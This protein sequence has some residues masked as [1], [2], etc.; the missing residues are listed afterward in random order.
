MNRSSS[1]QSDRPDHYADYDDEIDLADY[2]RVLIKRKSFILITTLCFA[3]AG[4]VFSWMNK[5]Y[6]AQTLILLSLKVEEK[7]SSQGET[8]GNPGSQIVIPTLSAQTYEVLATTD[9]MHR[10]LRD[11]LTIAWKDSANAL[12]SYGLNA[13]I[14]Q[15]SGTSPSQLLTFKV[16]SPDPTA[17]V[18]V[19]NTWTRLF[20]ERNRGLSSGVA[21]SYYD[22]ALDQ[23][24]VARINLTEA[25]MALQSLQAKYHN[26]NMVQNEVNVKNTELDASLISYQAQEVALASKTR[27]L[28]YVQKLITTLEVN[29]EWIGF[30]STDQLPSENQVVHE[31]ESMAKTLTL[32]MHELSKLEQDSIAVTQKYENEQFALQANEQNARLRFTRDRQLDAIRQR[33]GT[34]FATLET[35]RV[36]LP[37]L[38]KKSK[39][40]DIELGVYRQNLEQ[41]KPFL[42][43]S[44][45]ITDEA[46]WDQVSHNGRVSENKQTDLSRYKLQSEQ[47][48]PVY[49]KLWAQI[50][51]LRI[52][53]DLMQQRIA[54]LD[55]EIPALQQDVVSG[56]DRLDS[57]LVEE[58]WLDQR[59]N[60]TRFAFVKKMDRN[61]TSLLS[62]LQR[63]RRLFEDLRVFYFDSKQ[64]AQTL[65]N[66]IE[67]IQENFAFQQNRFTN[68]RDEVEGLST[69][70]DSL[71]MQ[72]VQ[73]ERNIAVY[74][75][76]FTRFSQL[77]EEARI[78][79]EQAAGDLQVVSWAAEVGAR[80]G[81][82]Y[83]LIIVFAGGMVS[84][85]MAF[86]LEYVEKAKERLRVEA[87]QMVA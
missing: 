71:S 51:D 1:D 37:E 70:V 79:L 39:D 72:R 64:Q 27:E 43:L 42:V 55:V 53:K 14:M 67:R 16:T 7:G 74:Q 18:S 33:V 3:I 8:L 24:E 13:E 76:T 69:V 66:E 32:L 50:T 22:W 25:E 26:L 44:K 35:Y 31:P 34:L 5:T 15:Q 4:A 86:L 41:E 75:A 46:L 62:K 48:N 60:D 61:T 12:A 57:L 87:D 20:V 9:D 54:F 56:Q 21:K 36:E 81:L 29:G 49:Q 30:L 63:R 19:V 38:R 80:S 6:E 40:I 78:S 85:F 17:P 47:V 82:K 73:L 65:T 23:Y 77:L 84:I 28:N 83:F 59:L 11:S 52:N 10:N 58:K 45:A 2:I 68:W